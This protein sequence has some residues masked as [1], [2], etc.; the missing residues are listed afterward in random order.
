MPRK[1]ELWVIGIF[2][3]VVVLGT[4]VAAV[5]SGGTTTASTQFVS[6]TVPALTSADWSRGNTAAAVS[7]TEYG[8]FQCPACGAYEPIM[9]QLTKD[10]GSSVRFAFRN[11]PLYQIHQDAMMS[12]QAAEAA[13]LQG[14]YWEMH[15]LL[16]AK[17]NEWSLEAANT[18]TAKF[19]DGYAR[20]LGLDVAKFDT[21]INSAGVKAKIQKD[22]ASGDAAKVDH[23]PT[24][25]VNL[26]QI[27]NP[28]NYADFKAAIEAA[29]S[30]TTA[31]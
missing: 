30:T 31:Q 14:K 18:V 15:D 10:F 2:V 28:A 17:Q 12:A 8:D 6:T 5:T 1:T 19:F 4:I 29:L 22:M 16:Y 3:A 21:D 13:G 27:P 26:Q 11:Y 20:S 9:Q 23:T 7:V 24:F 25:F